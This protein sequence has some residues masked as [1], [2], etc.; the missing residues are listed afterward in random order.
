MPKTDK[1]PKTVREESGDVLLAAI[2]MDSK[3]R[4]GEF[5]ERFKAIHQ[6]GSVFLVENAKVIEDETY[7]VVLNEHGTP[8]V[9]HKGDLSGWRVDCRKK[10][11]IG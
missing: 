8:M 6:D 5:K 3:T 4:A 7:L 2:K 1:R 11:G 9:F 10:E